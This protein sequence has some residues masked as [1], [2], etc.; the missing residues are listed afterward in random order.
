MLV[1]VA[2]VNPAAHPASDRAFSLL[3]LSTDGL[4]AFYLWV[5][6]AAFAVC[7]FLGLWMSYRLALRFAGPPSALLATLAVW[8]ASSLPVYLYAMPFDALVI[9]MCSSALFV[10]L[11]MSVRD[12]RDTRARW[13]L[14]GVSGGL[15]VA[16]SFFN[17]ALLLAAVVEWAT[18]LLRRRAVADALA[19][20]A[21]F[22]GGASVVLAPALLIRRM[23]DG[24]WLIDGNFPIMHWSQPRLAWTAISA[25]HGAFLWTPILLVGALGLLVAIRRQPAAGSVLALSS[26]LLFYLVAAYAPPVGPSYGARLL[27]PLTPMFICGLAAVTDATVG[28]RGRAAWLAATAAAAMFIVWNCGLMLQWGTGLIPQNGPLNFAQAAANQVNIVPGAA[29]EFVIRY[30]ND[31]K[32]LVNGLRRGARE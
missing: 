8:L 31:R 5:A 25:E 19:E 3:P 20:G 14:W 21:L 26:A 23:A 30:T 24:E 18:R 27:L 28:H 4:A 13:A 2:L 32:A 7:G 16:A 11:W 10:T 29:K 6:A 1:S 15:A 9:A 12:G 17:A 22:L